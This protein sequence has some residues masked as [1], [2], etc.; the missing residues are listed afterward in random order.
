AAGPLLAA[1]GDVEPR[2]LAP[3][4]RRD[5][6]GHRDVLGLAGRAVLDAAGDRDVE[7]P[8]Q[9][10]E[11]L[12]AEEDLLEGRRDRRGV[13]ELTWRQAGGRAADDAADVVHPGLEAREPGRLELRD[14]VRH[15]L[16]CHPAKLDLLAR[17]HVGD[18]SARRLRDLAEQARLRGGEDAVGHP[19]AHHEMARRRLALEHAD[20]FQTLLVVVSDGAPP[21]AGKAHEILGDVEAVA[22]RLERLDLVHRLDLVSTGVWATRRRRTA[23]AFSSGC[24]DTGSRSLRVRLLALL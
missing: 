19:D 10:R 21:L 5:G 13:E 17:R 22:L 15:L 23:H 3:V 8:R 18:V 24:R 7:L 6:R 20:P 1:D 9:V 16:D 2:D 14:D 4:P 11:R 12:V